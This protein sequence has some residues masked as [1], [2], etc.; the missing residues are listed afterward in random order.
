VNLELNATRK[1][2]ESVTGRS[3][4]LFRPPFNADAEPQTLAEVIPVA[5]SRRQ[6]Y[7]TIGES[8]D[9]WDWQPG[10]TA[11]SIIARTIRQKDNGSM[12]LLHDAGGDTR[13]ETVKA[14]PAIIHYF[15]TH[16]YEF[17]T[18]ADVLGKTKDDLMP[19]TDDQPAFSALL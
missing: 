19:P 2:I 10:V 18:I 7:I 9:P 4:I 12:I 8:I 16:G 14:L 3:T 13:E 6:S 1:L 15:K 5:E 11:D 17:T